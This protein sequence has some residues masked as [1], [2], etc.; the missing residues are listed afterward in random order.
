[1]KVDITKQVILTNYTISSQE[2]LKLTQTLPNN[3]SYLYVTYMSKIAQSTDICVGLEAVLDEVAKFPEMVIKDKRH[4]AKRN[5]SI[6]YSVKP[7]V[8]MEAVEDFRD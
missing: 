3:R 4:R 6:N 7:V 2:W 5:R 1:M 8:S